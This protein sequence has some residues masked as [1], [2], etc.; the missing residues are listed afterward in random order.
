MPWISPSLLH[1][2]SQYLRFSIA[3]VNVFSILEAPCP[4]VTCLLPQSKSSNT[5]D[6]SGSNGRT[7]IVLRRRKEK[8]FSGGGRA[9]LVLFCPFS[10]PAFSFLEKWIKGM[11]L[12]KPIRITGAKKGSG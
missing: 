7:K 3:W 2:Y 8:A 12:L 9:I 10:F 1:T 6:E 5:L 4:E 11:D